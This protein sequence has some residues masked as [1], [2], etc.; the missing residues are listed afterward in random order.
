M[1]G[2]LLPFMR[3]KISYIIL[4]LLFSML[5]SL[6]QAQPCSGNST[7][8]PYPTK[9]F[10]IEGIMVN[11]CTSNEGYDELVR[12]RIGPNP[13][14]LNSI[15]NI[16]WPTAN[17]WQGFASFNSTN[18]NKI[19]TIN[20]SISAAGNCGRLIKVNPTEVV[21]AYAR[22]LIITSTVFSATAIDYSGLRDTLYV[23]LQ[24]NNNVA[25]GHFGNYASGPS[26]EVLIIRTS[27]CSDTIAYSRALLT[28]MDG[29]VGNEDGASVNY[30]FNG[31]PT[32]VNYGCVLPVT[33]VTCDAGTLSGTYCS[34]STVNLS[35]TVTGTS[36]YWWYP[37]N[38][39]AGSFTDSTSLTPTF[40][41]APAFTGALKFYLRANS[42][43]GYK[44][45]SVS[46]TVNPPSGSITIASLTDTVV[47]NRSTVNLSVSPAGSIVWTT[48][49]KGSYNQN[50]SLTPTYTPTVN[51]TT[52]VWFTATRSSSCGT[53]KDSVRVRFYGPR[54]PAFSAS[55][56][57]VCI[58]SG[59]ITL[60]PAIA[61]GTFSGANVSGNTF[62]PPATPGVYPVKYV[63]GS[64][65]CADSSSRN[66]HVLATSNAAFTLSDTVVCMGSSITLTPVTSG[67]TYYGATVTANVFTPNTPGV[68][69]ISYAVGTST[70]RDSVAHTY[71]VTSPPS[72]AFT[73]SDTV[74]C[75]GSTITITPVTPGGTYSG[76]V[77]TSNQFTAGNTAG[78]F[79]LS[80]VTGTGTCRDSVAHTY[81]VVANP[82]ATFTASDT[83]LCAGSIANLNPVQNGGIFSGTG[84]TLNQ[85]STNAPGIYT[86]TYTLTQ[87]SCIN[88]DSLRIRV[89]S[90][91]SA[92]FSL[93]DTL[94]CLGS[95]NITVTPVQA[96]GTFGGVTLTGNTYVP[97]APGT[98][99][100]WY[101]RDNGIC[102]DSMYRTFRIQAKPNPSFT[103]S[104][105]SLCQGSSAVTIIPTLAGGVFSGNDV[106]GNT[107]TPDHAGTWPVKYVITQGAC[108]DS[109]TKLI[110]VSPALNAAFTVSDTLV[111]YSP[112]VVIQVNPTQAGGVWKDAPVIGGQF[113]PP[114]QGT[115]WITYVQNNGVCYDSVSRKIEVIKRTSAAF[116]VSDT[117]VCEGDAPVLFTPDFP[118]GVFTGQTLNV[119]NQFIPTTAGTY[120]FTYTTGVAGCKD[121][122]SKTIRVAAK[123]V[124]SF[125][126]TPKPAVVNDS[127]LFTYTGTTATAYLWNFGD[128]QTS[129]LQNPIHQYLTGKMY[130][131]LLWVTTVDGCTDSVLV[132]VE[133][134][135]DEALFIPN[136]FTPNGDSINDRFVISHKGISNYEIVIYNRWG[137]LVYTSKNPDDAWDGTF[138]KQAC[139]ESV[140]VYLLTYTGQSGR[141]RTRNGTVTLIR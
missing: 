59:N 19:N 130:P 69:V 46:I 38:R 124:A 93:S 26:N 5:T 104:D 41:I 91:A 138:E 24:N 21:P 51:D 34:G 55:D 28:K 140:Y 50:N 60:T 36:C 107:F 78:V 115:Y 1:H 64:G 4:V 17:T 113:A 88:K 15:N 22:L 62:T 121:S 128:A 108:A 63:L 54:S 20:N 101:V 114:T 33:P 80:Y 13:L 3:K 111:C 42:G 131:V 8:G 9:C 39:A 99:A 23:A 83:V 132:D 116:T 75:A 118:G 12:L 40:T 134:L 58:S 94:L 53:L 136:V 29:T 135:D 98:F 109:S 56:T 32:Y 48:S 133:V 117:L 65:A 127:V 92:A 100:I 52:L 85:F 110:W 73:L 14:Q 43:C 81:R 27:S 97:Q 25:S 139:P 95:G 16:N 77:V 57:L 129:T 122:V 86:V 141:T 7:G 37:Q 61:G 10:E 125:T 47:C 71:R 102:K 49:G 84:V 44:L 79:V 106:S 45:D 72:A 96:G 11:A 90:R 74:V 31:T 126:H 68:F 105:T 137:T 30:S 103:I 66:I 112:G 70:C 119:S 89:V 6:S 76:A 123:P 18:L 82:N 35:G 87:G 67:G 2:L 120:K